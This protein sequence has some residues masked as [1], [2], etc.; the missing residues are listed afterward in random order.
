MESC[1]YALLTKDVGDHSC[2][3]VLHGFVCFHFLSAEFLVDSFVVV[4]WWSY[5]I[6][7]S[8]YHG[9]LLLPHLFSMIVF[10]G[11]ISHH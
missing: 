6:L 7:V 2:A 9:R 3:F 11:R 1:P 4:S 10:L 5:V 8:A